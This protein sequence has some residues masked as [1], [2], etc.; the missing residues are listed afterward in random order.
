MTMLTDQNQIYRY[1]LAV[2]RHRLKLEIKL[3]MWAVKSTLDSARKVGFIGRT[4]KQAL[5]F[6]LALEDRAPSISSD[7]FHRNEAEI[8]ADNS[9]KRKYKWIHHEMEKENG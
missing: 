9:V 8:K 1:G 5:K 3:P 2:L 7:I 4:R 6:V